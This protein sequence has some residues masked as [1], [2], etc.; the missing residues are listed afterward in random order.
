MR[1]WIIYLYSN[2]E[3]FSAHKA[4]VCKIC[5]DNKYHNIAYKKCIYC[6]IKLL[7]DLHKYILY[8]Q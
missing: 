2:Y 3:Y 1:K 8:S 6:K 4:F 5:L 7:V